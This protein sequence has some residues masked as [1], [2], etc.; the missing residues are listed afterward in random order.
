MPS[1]PELA[2]TSIHNPRVKA[3]RRL[4]TSRKARHAEQQI[5][6]E[7]VRLIDDALRSGIAPVALFFDPVLT[8]GN[9][10]ATALVEQVAARGLR[11][12][13]GSFG[14]VD[15]NVRLVSMACGPTA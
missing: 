5:V 11:C 12:F 13:R 7:G 6:V 15:A 8:A 1:Q 2:I 10:A 3:V 4:L 14:G 9:L